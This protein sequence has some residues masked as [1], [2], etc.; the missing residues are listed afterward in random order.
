[1]SDI[2]QTIRIND[3][4][5]EPLK[6]LTKASYAASDGVSSFVEAMAEQVRETDMV[7]VKMNAA[8]DLTRG[9]YYSSHDLRKAV[10]KF[11]N[12]ALKPRIHLAGEFIKAKREEIKKQ[13]EEMIASARNVAQQIKDRVLLARTIA[14]N[15]ANRARWNFQYYV[16]NAP[17]N[18]AEAKLAKS[19][20]KAYGLKMSGDVKSMEQFVKTLRLAVNLQKIELIYLTKKFKLTY[21]NEESLA[22]YKKVVGDNLSTAKRF[23]DFLWFR[24]RLAFYGVLGA[25]MKYGAAFSAI[26][27]EQIKTVLFI[28]KSIRGIGEALNISAYIGVSAFK[29]VQN[30][31]IAAVK[32]TRGYVQNINTFARTTIKSVIP[33]MMSFKT[34]AITSLEKGMVA[35]TDKAAVFKR[36]FGFFRA[37]SFASIRHVILSIPK[38]LAS[39]GKKAANIAKAV[40]VGLGK[41]LLGGISSMFAFAGVRMFGGA[42][43]KMGKI[44]LEKTK[45]V[46]RMV[47]DVIAQNLDDISMTEKLNAMWGDI[48]GGGG[49]AFAFQLANE[50]GESAQMVTALAA[51][52][53]YQGIGTDSFE[54]I[55]RFSDKVAALRPGETTENVAA[56][57]LENVKNGKDAGT[58]AQLLG[59]GQLMERKLRRS[60][61]ERALRRGDID[62]ALKIAEKIAEQA[63][64]TDEK[65]KKAGSGLAQE[66][67]RVNNIIDNFKQKLSE[68]YATQLKSIV[69]RVR[70][71]LESKKFK[72]LMATAEVV[73]KKIAGLVGKFVNSML[74]HIHMIAY[75]L[76]GALVIKVMMLVRA[77]TFLPSLLKIATVGVGGLTKAIN[78]LGKLTG[79]SFLKMF[80]FSKLLSGGIKGI[81]VAMRGAFLAHPI[82]IVATAIG[83]VAYAIGRAT[84]KIGSFAGALMAVG[85]LAENI[86]HNFD[87][88]TDDM[89]GTDPTKDMSNRLNETSQLMQSTSQ[90]ISIMT[91][92]MGELAN[93]INSGQ[94]DKEAGMDLLEQ[95]RIQRNDLYEQLDSLKGKFD[96]QN[97]ELK[98]EIEKRTPRDFMEGVAE[99]AKQNVSMFD[100]IHG[101]FDE[102]IGVQKDIYNLSNYPPWARNAV[103]SFL[104]IKDDTGKIRSKMDREEEL[105]WMK[106]F[107]DRQIMSNYT[108]Q[109]STT[110]NVT[111]NGVSNAAIDSAA[112][113]NTRG[114]ATRPRGTGA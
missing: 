48:R 40:G 31:G 106:A 70:E 112:F 114:R 99:L 92:Q 4:F 104:H 53:A 28:I 108:Y 11:N 95:M 97:A 24:T 101:K 34:L 82:G 64:I 52:S 36:E 33:M 25:A 66:F 77:L 22:K 56:S 55:M 14:R 76:G 38:V 42:L 15:E 85:K 90:S 109:T 81:G 65:Y 23:A 87:L 10:T 49:K 100:M 80:S 79:L 58:M 89:S 45:S 78:L 96:T 1:M 107:S 57:L 9:L 32:S 98:A 12:E 68:I 62:Q 16:A 94:Y 71:L 75:L 63:G 39:T 111:L 8:I 7:N 29:T 113:I 59:G 51:K 93:K 67:Q 74:D 26:A 17:K 13:K 19:G 110:R 47:R 30:F 18:F 83:G 86:K 21:L 2:S 103:K 5:S 44:Y 60:G 54:K 73:V 50:I 3:E 69:I 105:R 61:Y 43:D 20:L 41:P 46:M 72:Q 91:N 37:S 6:N 84:G 102:V 35:L 88:L 27:K